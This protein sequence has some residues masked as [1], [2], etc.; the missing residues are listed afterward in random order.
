MAAMQ[1]VY[2]TFQ[3]FELCIP[4]IFL[5]E[6]V[7]IIKSLVAARSEYELVVRIVLARSNTRNLGSNSARGV[8]VCFLWACVVLCK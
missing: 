5:G 1:I 8:D 3:S 2:V 7:R 4:N 6:F